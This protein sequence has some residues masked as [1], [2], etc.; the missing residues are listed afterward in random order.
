MTNRKLLLSAVLAGMMTLANAGQI[1]IDSYNKKIPVPLWKLE[2]LVEIENDLKK[3]RKYQLKNK[4]YHLNSETVKYLVE[5][6]IQMIREEGIKVPSY[7][8]VA[9]FQS[10]IDVESSRNPL[11]K[12]EDNASG[13]LQLRLAAWTESSDKPFS[14]AYDPIE[15]INAGIRY[16]LRQN[17]YLSDNFPGWNKLTDQQKRDNLN[18][19]Y[20]RGQANFRFRDEWEIKNSP[21]ET[22]NH[23]K[24]AG[25]RY[26]D[27]NNI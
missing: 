14:Q 21:L 2:R 20:N 6:R 4:D 13:L 9:F 23:V 12:S 11:A 22:R 8:D 25:N 24:R 3:Y 7:F 26:E 19:C 27:Y 1:S 10:A 5:K 16:Y 18:A 17:K 15:N